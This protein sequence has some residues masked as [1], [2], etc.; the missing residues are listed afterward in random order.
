MD[1]GYSLEPSM[2]VL[3]KNKKN[4]EFESTCNHFYKKIS[5]LK[6][7]FSTAVKHYSMI[8]WACYNDKPFLS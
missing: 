8:V 7:I 3:S 2:Y 4:I 1:C 5:H 6:M